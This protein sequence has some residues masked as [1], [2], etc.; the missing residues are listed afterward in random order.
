MKLKCSLLRA[1]VLTAGISFAT[2]SGAFALE[3]S[4]LFDADTYK[5]LKEKGYVERSFFGKE[6]FNLSLYPDSPLG[7]MAK[8]NWP[9][10]KDNPTFVVEEAY[11]IS[12]KELGSGNYAKTTIEYAS[13]VLR[14]VSKLEGIYYYS[15]SEKKDAVLYKNAYCIASH[16][17]ETRVDDDTSG[18][19]EGLVKYCILDDHTFGR[20][21]YT[22]HYNERPDE[23]S[24]NFVNIDSLKLGPIKGIEPGNLYITLVVSDC[25]DDMLVYLVTQ[26]K[27]PALKIIKSTIYDSF[28]SRL[29]AIYKWFCS[30]FKK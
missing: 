25:G 19:A 1:F 15:N 10:N 12:K 29:A 23:I 21:R 20:A 7:R 11:L 28:S 2:L 18:S 8:D 22:L 27:T 30:E 3:A 6:K 17:D 24:A 9:A 26:A 4:A 13:K 16:N 14:S 5:E